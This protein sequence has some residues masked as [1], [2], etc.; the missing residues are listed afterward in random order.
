[1]VIFGHSEFIPVFLGKIVRNNFEWPFLAILNL[2]QSVLEKLF[3]KIWN[4]HLWPFWIYGSLF[5]KDFLKKF[6]MAISGHSEFIQVF[7]GEIVRK[8]LEWWFLVIL[9]LHQSFWEKFSVKFR[10]PIF[11]HSEFMPVFLGK[12]VRKNLEQ[13]FLAILNLYKSYLEKLSEKM[14]NGNFRSF[15]IYTSHFWK[16]CLKKFG[17]AIFAHSEFMPVI[18]GKIVRKNLEWLFFAIPKLYQSFWEKLSEKIWNSHFWPVWIYASHSRKNCQKKYGMATFCHSKVIPV[19]LGK[20][21]RKNLEWP[22]LA[23]LN[24]YQSFW[25]K[26]SEKFRMAILAIQNLYKSFLEKLF[27]KIWNDDFWSF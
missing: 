20:I 21:V 8:N 22:F 27:E 23:I 14:W 10:I 3:E 4:S 11:G 25:E 24:F 5:G 26:L 2:Y 13:W 16:N 6:G 18:L 1:M 7:F 19:F 9:N 12:I 15:W 17:T